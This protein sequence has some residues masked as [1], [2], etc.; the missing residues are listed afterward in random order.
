MEEAGFPPGKVHAQEVGVP[1]E[2]SVKFIGV[3]AH[4]VDALE[5]KAAVGGPETVAAIFTLSTYNTWPKC[6]W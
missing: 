6:Q 3:P 1:V 2:L 5:E 4:T